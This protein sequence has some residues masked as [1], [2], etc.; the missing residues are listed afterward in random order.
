MATG[1]HVISLAF[2]LE[3]TAVVFSSQKP[4]MYKSDTD[5]HT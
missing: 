4:H 5:I 2:T 3:R 1:G